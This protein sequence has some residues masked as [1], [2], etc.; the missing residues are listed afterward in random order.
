MSHILE[1]PIVFDEIEWDGIITKLKNP[2]RTTGKY[3]RGYWSISSPDLEIFCVSSDLEDAKRQFEEEFAVGMDN[4]YTQTETPSKCPKTAEY[5]AFRSRYEYY[6]DGKKGQEEETPVGP[7]YSEEYMIQFQMGGDDKW[8]SYTICSSK[9]EAFEGLRNF[10][11][12][13]VADK[14]RLMVRKV[15]QW[16]EYI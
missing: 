3:E 8:W 1:Q 7:T 12:K 15:S 10:Q 9:E 5:E 2:I 16:E 4:Y 14:T 11:K 13:N 6:I